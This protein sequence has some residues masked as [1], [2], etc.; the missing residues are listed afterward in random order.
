VNVQD[1]IQSG[2]VESYVLGLANEQE[3]AE[4]LQFSLQYPEIKEAIE[5][6]EAQIEKAAFANAV[7]VPASIKENLLNALQNDF[8]KPAAITTTP[9]VPITTAPIKSMG[10]YLKYFA[11]ASIVLLV[12]SSVLNFYLYNQYK[13]ANNNYLAQL[14]E[15]LGVTADNR[16]YQTKMLDLY[17]N[18]QLMSDPN[19]IKVA[20]PGV[21]GKENNLTTVFWNSQTKEV[22]LL[23][24]KLPQAQEGK[25]YQLWALVDG[26]PIDAGLLEDCNG[27][28]KLKN[29]QKAQAFAITLEDKGGSPTPHLDQ[30]VVLGKVG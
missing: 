28:C 30:L 9:I 1:Y 21:A 15:N 7:P 18:M 17:N 13:T 19:I 20:M 3:I 8:T 10:N 12:C 5:N 14:K 25:Q 29:T 2:I 23:A 27:L 16:I 22:Y 4:L 11:A 26:K 24:N 6:F